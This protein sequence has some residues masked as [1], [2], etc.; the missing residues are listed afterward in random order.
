MTT[1][2]ALRVEFA[3]TLLAWPFLVLLALVTPAIVLSVA[4]RD[5]LAQLP[6]LLA[7]IAAMAAVLLSQTLAA[8]AL[9]WEAMTLVSAFLVATYHERRAVRRALF[10]YLIIGQIGAVC[11]IAVLA[12][13]AAHANSVAFAVIARAAATLPP[14]LRAA[15]VLLALAGFGS[16]AGLVPLHFW[17]PRAHP[18]APPAA[19]ALLSGVMLKVAIYGLLLVCAVLAAPVGAALG[20]TIMI[21][22]LLSALAGSLY[23]A[24]ETDLKRLLAFSSIE[25]V[26]IIVAALGFALVAL[27]YAQPLLAGIAL[28]ALLFHVLAHG[29]FKSLLFLG[30]GEIA[31]AAHTTDLEHLGGL[32]HTLR[33]SAPAILIGCF[34]A[35]ALPPLCGFASEWL[36]FQALLRAFTG[37][38]HV[39]QIAA[40]LCVTAIATASGIAAIAFTKAFATGMLGT[41]R[42]THPRTREPLNAA[43]AALAWLA[44]LALVLGAA[45]MLAMRPLFSLVTAIVPASAGALA[46]AGSVPVWIAGLPA[47]G[48]IAVLMLARARGVRHVATWTCGSPVGVRSQYSA[49]AFANPLRVL[50]GG[51]TRPHADDTMRTVAAFVQR[52][53]RRTRIVQAG[54][55]RIYL[56]YALAALIAVLVVVR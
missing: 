38:S 46:W 12:L 15:I 44:V 25:N 23:A 21:A 45:P 50:L 42:S 36:L 39:V 29:V 34:A 54:Y 32:M 40:V 33:Y 7:F 27:A 55:V 43:P 19:S 17:L 5:R 20:M 26:G 4:R 18:V 24:I 28:A 41:P 10:S 37:A 6:L 9:S 16:K 31:A 47:A 1:L 30:A 51:L 3:P 49:S 11:I 13:L 22:G 35:A 56:A 52:F 48:A 8:F 2:P 53:A 14:D